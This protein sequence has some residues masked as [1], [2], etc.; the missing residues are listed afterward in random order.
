LKAIRGAVEKKHE[1]NVK[2]IVER[3]KKKD[4]KSKPKKQESNIRRE[5]FGKV[6][7]SEIKQGPLSLPAAVYS[8]FKGP[9]SF[10][11]SGLARLPMMST[12]QESL[13][14][15]GMKKMKAP[16]YLAL[17]VSGAV[18]VSLLFSGLFGL[19]GALFEDALLLSLAPLVGVGAF[20]AVALLASTIPNGLAASRARKVDRVLPFALRQL[21]TQIKAGVSFHRALRSVSETDYG[22]LSEEF[23][24]VLGDMANGVSTEDALKSLHA[25]T[26][27][28]GLRKALT[29]IM[30]A[31]RSGGSLAQ[32]ISDIADDVSFETRM[33]IR[34]FTEKLNFVNILYIMI[35][36]VAPVGIA[37]LSAIMQIPMFSAG[38]PPELIYVGFAGVLAGTTVVIYATKSMEPVAW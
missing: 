33:S 21:A 29:Q 26:R 38:L 4:S 7:V 17:S 1:H 5:E 16:T 20:F 6:D 34:D 25:R 23:E 10:I 14:A 12:L 19:L 31:F 24:Q 9:L 15:A 2:R 35:G 27:S 13:D 37:I 3:L 22:V 18:V 36:T 30:R 11:A 32:I 28:K 8:S